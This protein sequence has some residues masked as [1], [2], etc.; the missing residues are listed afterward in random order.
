MAN[1]IEVKNRKEWNAKIK[2]YRNNGYFLITFGNRLAEL[3]KGNELV[4][5]EY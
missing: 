4:V 1:K 5:I 2:E 3:E